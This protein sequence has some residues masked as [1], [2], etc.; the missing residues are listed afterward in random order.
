MRGAWAG[1]CGGTGWTGGTQVGGGFVKGHSNGVASQR[2][3]QG[4]GTHVENGEEG[5]NYQW[6]PEGV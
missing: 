2:A 6:D 4:K 5:T 1:Q 3:V